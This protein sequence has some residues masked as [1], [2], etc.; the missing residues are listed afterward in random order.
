MGRGLYE[1]FP[2]FRGRLM[3]CVVCWMGCWVVRCWVVFGGWFA[4][5]V[6]D[7]TVFTQAGLFAL[8][9]ALFRLVESWG[10][11]PDFLLGHSVGEVVAA[12]VGGVFSLEDACVLVAAR[13]RL[14]GGCRGGGDG[15][16]GGCLRRRCWSRCWV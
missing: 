3:R 15:V 6:L 11:R 5:W 8:E 9:V 1:C 7:G 14:M 4:G 10:V 2:V 13:G 16:G 12:C